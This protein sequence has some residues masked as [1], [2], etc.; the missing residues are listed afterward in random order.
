[1]E[2]EQKLKILRGEFLT[3]EFTQSVVEELQQN[4][5]FMYKLVEKD[6]ENGIVNKYLNIAIDIRLEKEFGNN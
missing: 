1:M 2:R 4:N 6:Y 5:T 3:P